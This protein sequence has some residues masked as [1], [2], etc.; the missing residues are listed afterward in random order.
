M[1]GEYTIGCYQS[2]Y[3]DERCKWVVY[4][5]DHD[6]ANPVKSE[7]Q[8]TLL[9]SILIENG[10][11]F[12]TECSGSPKSVHEWVFFSQPTPLHLAYN[13]MRAMVVRGGKYVF[14]G[15]IFPKQAALNPEKPYGNLVKVPFGFHQVTGRRT[16]FFDSSRGQPEP[17]MSNVETVDISHWQPVDLPQ[18]EKSPKKASGKI[19]EDKRLSDSY[20][21]NGQAVE[22]YRY[23]GEVRP[24]IKHM[25]KTNMQL[26]HEDGHKL[27]IAIASE[28]LQSGLTVEDVIEAFTCQKDFSRNVTSYQVRSVQGYN[29]ATCDRIRWH[30]RNLQSESGFKIDEMCKTCAF[31]SSQEMTHVRKGSSK[32]KDFA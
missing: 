28:L 14:T 21:S 19:R 15:E 11:P 17:D 22:S 7:V 20:I 10:V 6:D 12:Y 32:S 31:C 24:C 23:T 5:I 18:N 3:P 4:D 26:R 27:R 16:Y 13:W 29:R 1:S 30:A 8:K 9:K 25:L 2:T